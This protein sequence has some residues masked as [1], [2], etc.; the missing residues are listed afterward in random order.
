MGARLLMTAQ[1][2]PECLNKNVCAL[3]R[4][5]AEIVLSKENMQNHYEK[6][7]DRC[8]MKLPAKYLDIARYGDAH[9]KWSEFTTCAWYVRYNSESMSKKE[10][11]DIMKKCDWKKLR[12]EELNELNE[13]GVVEPGK[14]LTLYQTALAYAEGECNYWYLYAI[15]VEQEREKQQ[16]TI[17]KKREKYRRQTQKQENIIQGLREIIRLWFKKQS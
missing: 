6:V 8:L 9:T 11:E 1:H 17:D 15:H 5:L 12:S 14:I 2:Y 13:F 3:E 10:K 16:E 7:V 4:Q